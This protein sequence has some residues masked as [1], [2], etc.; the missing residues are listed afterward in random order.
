MENKMNEIIE[1]IL[2]EIEI[3]FGRKQ[4]VST[5]AGDIISNYAPKIWEAARKDLEWK[6]SLEKPEIRKSVCLFLPILGPVLGYWDGE[7]WITCE[8]KEVVY[9]EYWIELP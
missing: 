9:P 2:N 7:M 8:D 6:D 1:S 3:I 4:L 5:V